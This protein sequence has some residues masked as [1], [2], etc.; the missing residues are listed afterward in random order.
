MVTTQFVQR[1]MRLV[2]ATTVLLATGAPTPA[3][4]AQAPHGSTDTTPL[5]TSL[6]PSWPR[7]FTLDWVAT[8][9]GDT[10]TVE[11]Y[12]RNQGN[13][14]ARRI[15]LLVDGLDAAD[16]VVE[17]RLVWLLP[18]DLTP[19]TR[20]YFAVPMRPAAARYRVTVYSFD[21]DKGPST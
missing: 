5:L 9:K 18:P 7:Y 20:Q 10:T 14:S 21:G 4:L 8:V 19:G 16:T 15:R 13:I 2:T 3:A 17:Q 12:I 1:A 6:S 11:G